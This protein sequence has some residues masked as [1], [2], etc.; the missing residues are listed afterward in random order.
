M[1]F[2]VNVVMFIGF[3]GSP[4]FSFKSRI[5]LFWYGS[6]NVIVI[7]VNVTDVDVSDVDVVL[8]LFYLE[9]NLGL[10]DR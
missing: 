7:I 1:Y 3:I 4:K 9:S 5:L 10:S 8:L 6:T 2:N